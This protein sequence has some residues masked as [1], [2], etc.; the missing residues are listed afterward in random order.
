M[1]GVIA[2]VNGWYTVVSERC[3]RPYS[4]YCCLSRTTTVEPLSA[5]LIIM[6][7]LSMRLDSAIRSLLVRL[8]VLDCA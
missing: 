5:L 3:L 8:S 6:S 7:V 1:E 2:D 4:T